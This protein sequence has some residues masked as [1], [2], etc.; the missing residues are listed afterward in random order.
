VYPHDI[1]NLRSSA[2]RDMQQMSPPLA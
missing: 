1:S 2:A